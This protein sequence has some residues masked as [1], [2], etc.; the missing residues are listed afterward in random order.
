MLL[1][2]RS[3]LRCFDMAEAWKHY[4]D[5]MVSKRPGSALSQNNFGYYIRH[6]CVVYSSQ[7]GSAIFGQIDKD[8]ILI[9]SHHAPVSK[10]DGVELLRKLAKDDQKVVFAVT[11]DMVGMLERLG[12][13][14][15]H[16]TICT[17]FRGVD[18]EKH[19]LTN[20]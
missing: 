2:T 5:A 20:F 18:V 1:S 13:K 15:S 9:V 4:R 16:Q 6:R 7:Q 19:I 3:Y 10:R 12:F 14:N 17:D 8:G 11:I